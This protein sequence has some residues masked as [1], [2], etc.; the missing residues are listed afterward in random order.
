MR[1]KTTGPPGASGRGAILSPRSTAPTGG[2]TVA[3]RPDASARSCRSRTGRTSGLI[4][5]DA[6]DPDTA[7]PPIE[8]LRPPEGAPNVLVVLIDD[9]RLRRLERVRRAVRDA[10]RRA[11]RRRTA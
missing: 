5:Y 3:D 6:K 10:D 4:T 2:N 9:V 1:A 7:F 8:P 11:A